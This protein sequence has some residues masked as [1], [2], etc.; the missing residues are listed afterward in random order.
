MNAAYLIEN[1]LDLRHLSSVWTKAI[2]ILSAQCSIANTTAPKAKSWEN[3]THYDR[4]PIGAS[5]DQYY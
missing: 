2:Y 4:K 5:Q 1:L 3:T